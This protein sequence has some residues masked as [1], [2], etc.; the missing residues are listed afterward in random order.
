MRLA[1]VRHQRAER[2]G[3]LA[4]D[5]ELVLLPAGA[6][7][8]VDLVVAGDAGRAAAQQAA[9]KR[10]EVVALGEVT[11][12]PPVRRLRRDILCAGWNYWDHFEEGFGRRDGQDVPRPEHPTFFTKGPDTVVGPTDQIGYDPRLSAKWDYEAELAVVIGHTGR[13]IPVADAG[14]F[15]WGYTLANDIS[16]RDLQRA[17]GGQWLK[18]KSIDGTM[19]LGPWLVTADELGCPPDLRLQCLVNGE[20]LQD[21]ST[22]QMAFD[23]PTLISELSYGMTLRPGDLLLTGTPSGVGNAREPQRFLVEGDEVVVRAA[24]LG[25]LRN[26]LVTTDL[27]GP[28]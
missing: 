27:A 5:G 17:H 19:P 16:H 8:L 24:G 7:D 14:R 22:S 2:V 1:T 13:S 20:L 6:G 26:R 10:H 23:I 12:L 11:L 21:A 15:V 9:G 18:G 28:A 25:E 3:V 4:G